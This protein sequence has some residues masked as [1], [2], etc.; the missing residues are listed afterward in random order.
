M[1]K[2]IVVFLLA[3]VVSLSYG[4]DWMKIFSQEGFDQQTLL[5]SSNNSIGGYFSLSS[6]ATLVDSNVYPVAGAEFGAIINHSLI[7]GFAGRGMPLSYTMHYSPHATN[8]A[9]GAGWGGLMLGYIFLP[10]SIIH[11][12]IKVLIGSGSIGYVSQ[13]DDYGGWAF[14][15]SEA[16]AGVDFNIT[17]WCRVS[18]YIGYRYVYGNINILN[19]TDS[20][21][22]G[23]NA[24]LSLSFG[25]F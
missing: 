8:D 1:R 22:S 6:H 16:T 15:A 2:C 10:Q 12:F 18:P 17:R 14:F 23:F 9:S 7:I 4:R 11:P 13:K 3:A 24:G 19:L 25:W 5:D 20:K 21:L